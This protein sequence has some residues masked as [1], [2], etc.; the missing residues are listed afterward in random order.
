MKEKEMDLPETP[1]TRRRAKVAR[2]GVRQ[3]DD[4][5]KAPARAGQLDLF[6]W[7]DSLHSAEIVAFDQRLSDK[8]RIMKLLDDLES[9]ALRRRQKV[10]AVVALRVAH[11]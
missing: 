9:G 11:G 10:A 3:D 5:R 4:G 2:I 7:A 1:E 8:R 6:A